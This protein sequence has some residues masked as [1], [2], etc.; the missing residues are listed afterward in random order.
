M[1]EFL[2]VLTYWQWGILAIVLVVMEVVL[3]G[4]IFLWVG[5][6]AG[7]TG[8]LLLALPETSWK[9]QFVSFAISSI[10]AGI[11][12]RMYVARNPIQTDHPNLN[13][14]GRRHIDRVLALSE[15][16]VNGHGKA[17]IDGTLWQIKGP[18]LEAGVSIRVVDTDGATLVV[19]AMAE[20]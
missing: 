2:E 8:L 13:Q 11:V 1:I 19:E 3:P 4:V 12:G 10:I 18:D 6:G 7:I 14:R 9:L 15:P 5:I 20:E 16:I 17:Q